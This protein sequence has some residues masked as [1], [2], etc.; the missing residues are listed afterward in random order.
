[1]RPYPSLQIM[2][3][4]LLSTACGENEPAVSTAHE[5]TYR[6][7]SLYINNAGCDSPGADGLTDLVETHLVIF[8]DNVVGVDIIRALSCRSIEDCRMLREA[9]ASVQAD[10]SPVLNFSFQSTSG[11]RMVGTTQSTGF[12]SAVGVCRDPERTLSILELEEANRVTIESTKRVGDTYPETEDGFCTTELGAEA[13][14]NAPCSYQIEL[15]AIR[16]ESP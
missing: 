8:T 1:V 9:Y 16:V 6:L 4:L 13:T 15:S 10:L 12:T 7:E 11:A 2:C 5:G 3:L 14:A